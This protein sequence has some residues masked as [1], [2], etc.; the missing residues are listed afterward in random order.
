MSTLGWIC[1]EGLV[2]DAERT[3]SWLSE[4]AKLPN[5]PRVK[6]VMRTTKGWHGFNFAHGIE[7]VRPTGYRRDSRIEFVIEGESNLNA[8]ELEQALRSCVWIPTGS[9]AEI[10]TGAMA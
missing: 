10:K 7:E 6:A 8:E 5:I 1:W 3:S 4:M 2:F 9:K